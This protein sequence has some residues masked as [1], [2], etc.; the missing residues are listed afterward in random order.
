[1]RCL[2]VVLTVAVVLLMG[3]ARPAS[4]AEPCDEWDPDL[5]LFAPSLVAFGRDT[6]VSVSTDYAAEVWD[7]RLE[8]IDEDGTVIF[9]RTPTV[10][11]LV[12]AREYPAHSISF[13]LRRESGGPIRVRV[14]WSERNGDFTCD[15]VA[16]HRVRFFRGRSPRPRFVHVDTGDPLGARPLSST[17]ALPAV[18]LSPGPACEQLAPG[19]LAVVVRY[20]GRRRTFT[21]G[22]DPCTTYYGR[23]AASGQVIPSLRFA[24]DGF[25]LYLAVAGRRPWVR[26]YQIRVLWNDE[27]IFTRRL[28]VRLRTYRPSW[29][30]YDHLDADQF[31]M[32]CAGQSDEGH[33]P[34][35]KDK[36]GREYCIHP[37][38]RTATFRI[39][40]PRT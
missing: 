2:P 24:R 25:F 34:V 5:Q 14:S 3:L 4:A 15:G 18:E 30:I 10:E 22:P 11:Q 13:P 1:V 6:S 33:L 12:G 27:P 28:R 37:P 19:K 17:D 35:H 20:L 31:Y 39:L 38:R 36:K 26:T 21:L 16:E 32:V 23:W 40:P 9:S 7:A 29:R 8:Y